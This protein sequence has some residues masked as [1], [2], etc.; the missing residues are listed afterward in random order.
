MKKKKEENK[1]KAE[2]IKKM[3]KNYHSKNK[4]T[5]TNSP[6]QTFSTSYLKKIKSG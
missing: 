6:Q 1:S 2:S 4:F 5:I 3:A